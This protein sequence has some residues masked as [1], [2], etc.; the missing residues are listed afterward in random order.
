MKL[1]TETVAAV[2]AT[3]IRT[4]IL[5]GTLK[6][7]QPLRQDALSKQLNISRTPL[8]QALQMLTEEG[9]VTIAEF[10]GA[11]VTRLD[12]SLLD[13]LFDMRLVLES[14]ALASALPRL[15][16]RHLAEAEMALDDAREETAPDKLSVFN[17]RF[18]D[19]LYAPSERKLLLQTIRRL[20]STAAFAELIAT[21]IAGR[22]HQSHAE[23]LALLAACREA[24]APRAIDI[25]KQ[26]LTLAHAEAKAALKG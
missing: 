23:H 17:W 5:N 25:L 21:S 14:M 20:N 19:A 1:H 15:T 11:S 3:S 10:K 12:A 24:N 7:G 9:L 26:H 22:V 8:R 6:A 2:A 4:L 16:K 18:H 13:D